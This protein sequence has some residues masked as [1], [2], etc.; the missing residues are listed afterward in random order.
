ME[1]FFFRGGFEMR[2][3]PYS[4]DEYVRLDSSKIEKTY[5]FML[6]NDLTYLEINDASLFN[7]KDLNFLKDFGFLEKIFVI[8]DEQLDIS[9]IQFLK[10][11]RKIDLGSD[12]KKITFDFNA[13][14]FLEFY[15]GPYDKKNLTPFESQTIKT[16]YTRNVKGNFRVFSKMLN[17]EELLVEKINAENL[18]GLE[19]LSKLRILDITSTKAL[20]FLQPLEV[21]QRLEELTLLFCKEITSYEPLRQAKQLKRLHLSESAPTQSL[22]FVRDLPAL[23]RIGVFIDVLDRDLSPLVGVKNV[24]LPKLSKKLNYTR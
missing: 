22:D 16:L 23:E 20:R 11:I 2:R 3:M 15:V 1:P 6:N 12:F 17:L 21:L 5:S 8:G 10:N 7:L 24:L 4:G 9:G 19:T 13:F 18:E 14:P